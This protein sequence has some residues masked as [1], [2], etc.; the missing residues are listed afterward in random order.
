MKYLTEKDMATDW[1]FGTDV[2]QMRQ[3]FRRMMDK[4]PEAFATCVR[5]YM[6]YGEE[7]FP[8]IDSTGGRL[9]TPR[10][11]LAALLAEYQRAQNKG[12]TQNQF[13][14]SEGEKGIRSADQ[15]SVV[16]WQTADTIRSKLKEARQ[17]YKLD[18]DFRAQVEFY[19]DAFEAIGGPRG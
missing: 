19:R 2:C 6:E 4:D 13:L 1:A 17:L 8:K 3:V 10:H 18:S 7:R 15:Y 12:V 11:S 16:S 14:E 5:E 9:Q